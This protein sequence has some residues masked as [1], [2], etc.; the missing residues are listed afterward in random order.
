[1][2]DGAPCGMDD[3]SVPQPRRFTAYRRR[4]ADL[5]R[6]AATPALLGMKPWTISHQPAGAS[7]AISGRGRAYSAT[8]AGTDRRDRLAADAIASGSHRSGASAPATR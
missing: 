5:C 2:V 1:M 6:S 8:R 4:D 7:L 3:L